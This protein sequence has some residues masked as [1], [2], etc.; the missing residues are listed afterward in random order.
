MRAASLL[1]F[2]LLWSCLLLAADVSGTWL[3]EVNLDQGSGTPTFILDQKGSKLSG[4]YKG[5]FGEAPLT[6]TVDGKS[7]KFTFTVQDAKVE[8]EGTVEGPKEMKGKV[9]Y[10]DL[11]SGTWTATK[12]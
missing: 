6:G 2:A 5:Q 8:Y 7:I 11:A 12:R 1:I 3:F 9:R 10:G 4:T